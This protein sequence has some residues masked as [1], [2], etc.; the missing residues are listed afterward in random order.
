SLSA[1]QLF[2][3]ANDLAHMQILA[4]VG[5][6]DIATIKEAQKVSFSVQALPKKSFDGIVEQVRLQSVTTENVV[7]YTVVVNVENPKQE[8]LPGMTARV[9]FLVKTADNVLKVPNAALRFKPTEEQLAK[10]R[11]EAK[12]A[13]TTATTTTATTTTGATPR[14]ARAGRAGRTGRGDATFGTLYYRDAKNQLQMARVR[15]G[16]SDKTSTEV[17][18]RT[19]REGMK[20]IAG[21]GVTTKTASTESASP[22]ANNNSNANRPRGGGVGF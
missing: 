6:S 11:A 3:I 21:S 7:N 4:K 12:P 10:L 14:T 1:P 2:L 19:I 17:T 8:L 18:G 5:E 22:F 16:I 15:T 20:V 9:D 13:T